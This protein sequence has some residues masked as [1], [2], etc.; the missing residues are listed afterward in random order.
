M[1]TLPA[2]TVGETRSHLPPRSRPFGGRNEHLGG[3]RGDRVTDQ[4]EGEI[5]ELGE[6]NAEL[7]HVETF[8]GGAVTLDETLPGADIGVRPSG[9]Q[10]RGSSGRQRGRT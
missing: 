7:A 9:T 4:I 5:V 1:E 8:P 6:S 10:P 3:S 2:M